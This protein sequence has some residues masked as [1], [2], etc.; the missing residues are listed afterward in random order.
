MYTKY[1][2]PHGS[3]NLIMFF[4]NLILGGYCF[5]CLMFWGLPNAEA[6]SCKGGKPSLEE[7][8]IQNDI[9]F[10]GVVSGKSG[11]FTVYE[12]K[13]IYKVPEVYK[14][15][16]QFLVGGLL[17]DGKLDGVRFSEALV[18]KEMIIYGTLRLNSDGEE[19][20]HISYSCDR[21]F[22]TIEE[23]LQAVKSKKQGAVEKVVLR[24]TVN[25][26]TKTRG[27]YSEIVGRRSENQL[28]ISIDLDEVYSKPAETDISEL[29]VN[30]LRV[31]GP[32]CMNEFGL[33][34]DYVLTL[35]V[36]Q[37]GS[38]L[39]G[40]PCSKTNIVAFQEQFELKKYR[41]KGTKID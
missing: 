6:L 38:V 19:R 28:E 2:P 22:L 30:K 3:K 26:I 16:K 5:F 27:E 32:G 37:D 39:N 36:K 15:K 21:S 33:G 9:V 35:L 14:D 13:E 23:F 18:G 8:Y 4:R 24:G 10:K 20:V 41:N 40:I 7:A 25:R 12:V 34:K 29:N 11:S 17:S 1:R 31:G